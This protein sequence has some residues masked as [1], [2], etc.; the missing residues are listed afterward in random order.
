MKKRT[1]NF[2]SERVIP[3]MQDALHREC[4]HYA[5]VFRETIKDKFDV[6]VVNVNNI[7]DSQKYIG[8]VTPKMK[9]FDNNVPPAKDRH[10]LNANAAMKQGSFYKKVSNHVNNN[11]MLLIVDATDWPFSVRVERKVVNRIYLFLRQ[12]G[13]SN[14]KN[15]ILLTGTQEACK[16]KHVFGKIVHIE[17][18]ECALKVYNNDICNLD[19]KFKNFLT[20]NETHRFLYLNHKE[21]PHRLYLYVKFFTEIKNMYKHFA[22][23]MCPERNVFGG[24]QAHYTDEDKKVYLYHKVSLRNFNFTCFREIISRFYNNGTVPD[25]FFNSSMG[26]FVDHLSTLTKTPGGSN[27][28]KLGN[29]VSKNWSRGATYFKCS[30]FTSEHAGIYVAPETNF[31]YSR[32]HALR[33]NDY[34]AITE[35]TYKPIAM[36]M[37]FI[38]YGQPF[39]LRRLREYGYRTF[40]DFWDESYDEEI[41]PAKRADKIVSAVKK[42]N[43]LSDS[44]FMNLLLQTRDT[45][46]HN[47]RNLRERKSEKEMCDMIS[48]FY[49]K[50][51]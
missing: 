36:K 43:E 17:I 23:S 40:S 8:F 32:E 2:V 5:H 13:I 51:N 48:D 33:G 35:K 27:V 50:I 45:V 25:W 19:R 30:R 49:E 6:N 14:F 18:H 9:V 4:I 3:G 12:C 39:I 41:D 20:N 29:W 7:V 24:E 44:E 34:L 46:E 37:P 26:E 38:M 16:E 47:Y 42:L 11:K 31:F 15:V 22:I 28:T 10:I 21:R 1:I